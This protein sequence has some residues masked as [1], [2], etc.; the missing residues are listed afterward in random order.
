[1]ASCKDCDGGLAVDVQSGELAC[2]ECGLVQSAKLT[3]VECGHRDFFHEGGP[4]DEQ[5]AAVSWLSSASGNLPA[6]CQQTT[7][8][9]LD[10][11]PRVG[12]ERRKAGRKVLEEFAHVE[13]VVELLGLPSVVAST[14]HSYLTTC[15]SKRFERGNTRQG[16]VIACIF[17][18]CRSHGA[19][20]TARELSAVS[21]V[22]S[23]NIKQACKRTSLFVASHS[24]T[25]GPKDMR[26]EDLL[27][28]CCAAIMDRKDQK[29]ARKLLL[30]CRQRCA[31]RERLT[32]L[33]GK[34]PSTVAAVIIWKVAQEQR[35]SVSRKEISMGCGITVGTLVKAEHDYDGQAKEG[36]IDEGFRS[37]KREVKQ[38]AGDV[39]RVAGK[40]ARGVGK[41]GKRGAKGVGKVAGKVVGGHKKRGDMTGLTFVCKAVDFGNMGGGMRAGAM[42]GPMAPGQKGKGGA[43]KNRKGPRN[44]PTKGM[45]AERGLKPSKRRGTR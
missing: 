12:P 33:Q 17:H 7:S 34:T 36:F 42:I 31:V 25:E 6:L 35:L 21:G 2:T 38:A 32:V 18:A 22:P 28:R 29:E 45:V 37:A 5:S 14:A 13:R 11:D 8:T 10:R 3:V 26:P 39:E 4:L 30:A 41:A 20:R 23:S 44:N 24:S 15:L 19:P 27:A 40:A 1:M 43:G 9:A 16:T